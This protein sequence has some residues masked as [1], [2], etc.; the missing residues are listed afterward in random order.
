MRFSRDLLVLFLL[1]LVVSG[2]GAAVTLLRS[3]QSPESEV[4]YSTHT[5]ARQGTQALQR[6]LEALGYRSQR[7]EGEAFAIPNDAHV[8]FTLG[9]SI[10][11]DAK[12]TAA[13]LSW[14]DRGNTLIVAGT[15]A[16]QS[17]LMRSL[18]QKADRRF[19]NRIEQ[20]SLEQPVLGELPSIPAQVNTWQGLSLDRTDY[21]QYLSAD[22]TPILVSFKRNQ[23]R[24]WLSSAPF[25]FTNDGLNNE[26]NAALVGA[27]LTGVPPGSLVAFDEYHLGFR[28]A[29]QNR[30]NLQ[31]LLYG[32][33]A[34]WAILYALV[35]ILGFLI[36]NGRRLGRVMPLPLTLAR[37]R[38]VEYVT[39]VAQLLQRAHKQKMVLRHY[40]QQLKRRLGHPYQIS[41]DLPDETFIAALARSDERVDRQELARILRGFQDKRIGANRLVQLV[42][43]AVQFAERRG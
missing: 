5:V 20:V 32:T 7:I 3:S 26:T 33:P 8:L 40:R 43:Q 29:A 27:M 19:E 37:R 4:A 39:S 2:L 42:N 18:Q 34:G 16:S 38:P 36:I 22:R 28:Q 41:P 9:Q 24:I 25:L 6:W 13:L 21:V 11:L 12:E 14:V 17:V 35:V 10:P 15:N 31:A 30:Q 23:G 1:L